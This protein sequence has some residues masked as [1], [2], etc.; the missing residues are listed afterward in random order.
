M[1][2]KMSL[3]CR[4]QV[5]DECLEYAYTCACTEPKAPYGQV[6]LCHEIEEV[7][8]CLIRRRILRHPVGEG[9]VEMGGRHEAH[10]SG[11]VVAPA[12]AQ[13][14]TV[15]ER[16]AGLAVDTKHGLVIGAHVD[17]NERIGREHDGPVE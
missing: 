1:G 16:A 3:R 13:A 8:L 7:S 4:S 9:F 14:V 17:V 10:E 5:N 11:H 15:L 2:Q 12:H 6:P